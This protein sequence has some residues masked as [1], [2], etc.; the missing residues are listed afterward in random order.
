[1][2]KLI[3]W[4]VATGLALVATAAILDHL[5]PFPEHKLTPPSSTRVLDRHGQPL[6]YFLASDDMWRFP[7]TL[8]QVA[9]DFITA[10]IASEDRHFYHHP[11][12]NPFSALR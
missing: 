2:K 11:G 9:P 6:R 7:V 10:L 4:L 1:M 12:V 3:C 8:D 5:F